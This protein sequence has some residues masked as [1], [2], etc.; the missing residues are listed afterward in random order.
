MNTFVRKQYIMMWQ[1]FWIPSCTVCCPVI[2]FLFC[3]ILF[4]LRATGSLYQNHN[5]LSL[6]F[7]MGKPHITYPHLKQKTVHCLT[8]IHYFH[9]WS[10]YIDIRKVCVNIWWS[11][12]T[13]IWL[14]YLVWSHTIYPITQDQTGILPGP[15]PTKDKSRD[16][17]KMSWH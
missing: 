16:I 6:F 12:Q 17:L 15:R 9:S 7:G 13:H 5:S 3:F 8:C 14:N 1:I 4:C 10:Y 2:G 11:Y